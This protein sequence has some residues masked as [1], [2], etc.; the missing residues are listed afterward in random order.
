MQSDAT[1]WLVKIRPCGDT[2]DPD[3][4]PIRMEASRRLSRNCGVTS[5]LYLSLTCAAG[6]WLNSHMPSSAVTGRARADASKRAGN[7]ISVLKFYFRSGPSARPCSPFRVMG[8]V[9]EHALHGL[10]PL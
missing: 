10:P 9:H 4:P 6:N 3:P 2:N 5:K 8:A 1:W 7:F